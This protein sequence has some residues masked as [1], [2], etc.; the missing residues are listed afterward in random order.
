MKAPL[1][2]HRQR[3]RQCKSNFTLDAHR[4]Q[5]QGLHAPATARQ[6]A[7]EQ[8]EQVTCKCAGMI[9]A[10]A[11]AMARQVPIF[12]LL[13]KFD[14]ARLQ[15]DIKAGRRR[16][17]LTRLPAFLVLHVK[18]FT[19]NNFFLEK[20]PTIVNFPVRNLE[21]RDIVPVPSGAPVTDN[22]SSSICVKRYVRSSWTAMLSIMGRIGQYC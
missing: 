17:R 13:R 1:I 8:E 7:D 14:G 9:G 19:K 15:D 3:S 16:Y 20:N 11:A 10:D 18:R 2:S 21:L 5:W 4:Q 12:E 22:C 6:A